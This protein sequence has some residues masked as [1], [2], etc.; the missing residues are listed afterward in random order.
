MIGQM[1]GA[2]PPQQDTQERINRWIVLILA[3]GVS[4]MAFIAAATAQSVFVTFPILLFGSFVVVVVH[5]LGHAIAAWMVGWRVWII[6]AAP[7]VWR[8]NADSVLF[9]GNLGGP[10]LGGFVLATPRTQREDTKWRDCFV[11]A[12]GPLASWLM[13]AAC[14][15]AAIF[16][17]G[18]A[19]N[20]GSD[21][22][23]GLYALG[24]LS[25]AAAIGSSLPVF[26]RH[27]GN[28]AMHILAT[29]NRPA[30]QARP[31]AENALFLW[32]YGV[33]P[34]EWDDE[35]RS[36]VEAAR[37]QPA[38]AFVPG[39]FD[40]LTAVR[41]DDPSAARIALATLSASAA[42]SST[43]IL[44]AYVQTAFEDDRD[45]ADA[46]LSSLRLSD[47][48]TE[49]LVFR[50]F[51]LAELARLD[52]DSEAARKRLEE[53]KTQLSRQPFAQQPFWTEL[54]VAAYARLGGHRLPTAGTI[55]A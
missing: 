1:T 19:F 53:L 9:A 52:G 15:C 16:M 55:A 24:L 51:T 36:S 46:L 6:H 37:Y 33:E 44:E 18:G 49:D 21:W 3:G 5:E 47:V 2:G 32:R 22:R 27:G 17:G 8:R 43:T 20:D 29:L 35:L 10:D 31:H 39:F 12:G 45:G 26:S 7:F 38:S 25:L 4:L 48:T 13:A 28:D 54:L 50:E 14:I 41:A 40:F 11:S 42:D 34:A 30:G 23:A